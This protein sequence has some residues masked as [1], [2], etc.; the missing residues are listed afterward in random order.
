[1]TRNKVFFHFQ[2]KFFMTQQMAKRKHQT[3]R[4]VQV[5]A[6]IETDS[7]NFHSAVCGCVNAKQVSI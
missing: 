1:M 5:E 6:D 7:I 3:P 2:L 4:I